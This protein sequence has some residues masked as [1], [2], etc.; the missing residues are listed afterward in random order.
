MAL[1]DSIRDI[2]G[3]KKQLL[4]AVGLV[5]II[6]L[7]VVIIIVRPGSDEEPGTLHMYCLDT[8][9]EFVIP[10]DEIKTVIPTGDGDTEYTR[11]DRPMPWDPL[12][13]NPKTGEITCI[14]MFRC[15]ACEKY[16]LPAVWLEDPPSDNSREYTCPHCKKSNPEAIQEKLKRI[17]GR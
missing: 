3:D 13:K 16:Y 14:R 4:L 1:K 5:A 12:Y 2:T 17:K 10:K 9:E 11:P 6:A 15:P 7:T 8:K